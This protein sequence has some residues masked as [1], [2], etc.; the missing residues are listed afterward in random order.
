MKPKQLVKYWA[1]LLGLSRWNINLTIVPSSLADM[2]SEAGEKRFGLSK[3]V[4]N[5]MLVDITVLEDNG[6]HNFEETLVHE[7]LHCVLQPLARVQTGDDG[8]N[9]LQALEE[10]RIIEVLS[11]ALVEAR[12]GKN[13]RHVCT[14]A[15]HK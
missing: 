14:V 13:I 3:I 12:S 1:E 10:E 2:F 11:R 7:L 9:S 5:L 4:D 6:Q 15:R 8:I